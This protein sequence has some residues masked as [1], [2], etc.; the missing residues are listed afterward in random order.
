MK[1]HLLTLALI[2][3]FM[4]H[5]Q[6]TIQKADM[7]IPNDTF[8]ISTAS[9][10]S[11][12]VFKNTGANYTWDFTNLQSGGQ[13]MES[14][15]SVSSTPLIYN[16]VFP[17][18]LVSTIARERPDVNIAV[19]SLQ[20]GYDFFKATNSDFRQVGFGAE[21][22]G[23]PLPVQFTSADVL[24]RF[25][26]NYG[27]IDSCDAA[28]SVSIPNLGYLGE[29]KHRINKVDGWG[30][31]KT[32]YGNFQCLRMMSIV[33]Q[34]DSFHYDSIPIPF[35]AIPQ[36]FVEYYW[37]AKG[38]GFP[39]VKVTQGITTTVEYIDSI[40]VFPGWNEN[41]NHQNVMRVYPNPAK[42]FVQI[43]FNKV[44]ENC[45]IKLMDTEGRLIKHDFIEQANFYKFDVRNLEKG[46][47]F[48]SLQTKNW[49]EVK[50]LIIQ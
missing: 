41:V 22:Q 44:V 19:I 13:N 28:W 34:T 46:V 4:A 33:N 47:Y 38:V 45:E 3:S 18:P 25:P 36:K 26:M 42:D 1:L 16:I 30:T 15:V 32:P 37:L 10:A 21:I 11:Q 43:G 50:Q 8:R 24:Y 27:N 40:M 48:V 14:Y 23:L 6:I 31:V 29:K 39:I 5:G 9:N 35:P 12:F 49:R 20:N 17:Y 7:P 2:V